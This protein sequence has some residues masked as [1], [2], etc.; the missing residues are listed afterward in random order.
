MTRAGPP[1]QALTRALGS[2]GSSQ[3]EVARTARDQSAAAAAADAAIASAARTARDAS[4]VSRQYAQANDNAARQLRTMTG[5][6]ERNAFAVRNLGQQFG[7]MAVMI[8]GGIDPGRAFATQ[9]GQIGYAMSDMSGKMGAVGRFL[10]GPWGIALTIAAGFLAPMV[11]KMLDASNAAEKQAEALASATAAADTYGSA[12]SQLGK[13]IELTTGKLKTQ[14]LELIQSIRLQAQADMRSAKEAQAKAGGALRSITDPTVGETFSDFAKTAASQNPAITFMDTAI[15]RGQ[16]LG[17]LKKTLEDYIALTNIAGV[18]QANLDRGFM[19]T[20]RSIDGLAR[21]GKLAGR[22]AIDAKA[23][24]VALGTTLNKQRAA[25]M[26]I[27]A[28]DGK[29][30]APELVPFQRTK[31]DKKPKSTA[32]RD[33]FG[34]DAADKIAGIVSQFDETPAV[35]DKTNAKVRE[36]D[37]LID[38]LGRRKPLGFGALIE[39]AEAAKTVVREG[40][41]R[42]VGKAFEQPKTLADRA[43]VAIGQLDAAIADL[44]ARKPAGFEQLIAD[45][46]TTQDVIRNGLQKPYAD[47]IRQ[48]QDGLAVQKLILAGRVGE[49]EALRTVQQLQQQMGPLTQAQKDAVLAT[50]EAMRAQARAI[51]DMHARAAKYTEAVSGISTIVQDATQQFVRGDLGQLIK[52]PGRL[53]DAFQT[54]NGRALF[55][56]LFSGVFQD[57]QDE[58]NGTSVV[59]DA[60][61]RMA[62]AV[63]A[64]TASTSRTTAAIDA[65][66][67]SA[68]AAARSVPGGAVG[69]FVGSAGSSAPA[70]ANDNGDIIVTGKRLR[71][72]SKD[73]TAFFTDALGRVG[74]SVAKAFTNPDTAARV[75]GAIGKFAGIGLQGAATGSIVAGVGKAIGIKLNS[76][77]S[78]IGGALGSFLPIP[79][80]SIIGSVVGGLIGNLFGKKAAY[81]TATLSGNDQSNVS[82]GGNKANAKSGANSLAGAVQEGLAQIVQQLGGTLGSYNVSI[83]TYDGKYRV[84]TSGQTGSLDFGKKNKQKATLHDFGDDQAGAIAFAIADAIADGAI[85]GLSARMQQ[86]IHSSTDINKALNEALKVQKLELDLGGVQAQLNK[87]F[88]DF[89]DQARERLRIATTY[90]FDVVAVEKKNAED[91][92]ALAQ[93]L[94]AQQVGSLQNLVDEM[95]RGSLFEGTAKDRLEA[96][97]K[98]IAKAKADFDAGK[99]GA[100]DTYAALLQQKL[101]ASKETYGTTS[102]YAA[103]RAATLNAAQAAIAQANARIV[104]GQNGGSDP[105]LATTN[106]GIAET[107]RTLDENNDQNAQIITALREQ[108]ELLA[109]AVKGNGGNSTFFD[110]AALSRV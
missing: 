78:Q 4:N 56:K 40:L 44:S 68:A 86:A 51:D 93:Q 57:L 84:S 90:G 47:F 88:R 60:S 91:R 70:A 77:G 35:L 14:N 75:G 11:S 102:A 45:A 33:E 41:I 71:G 61:D 38:D 99:E 22:D 103:D 55:D 81:G 83:G 23:A 2:L 64:V 69:G 3:E 73:P 15:R 16:Q 52:N 8:Q 34:R 19:A 20:L 85:Q 105:A 80:G 50:T 32:A 26:T 98:S 76:T 104:A 94:A 89:E 74:T 13:I 10:V 29:G 6:A 67:Q 63:D 9:A 48:Q 96:I 21:A 30:I 59:K 31:K 12:Q 42:E 7:D 49:A 107:N 36:L 110:L 108:N 18:S 106:A 92:A 109:K 95:T 97:N 5:D 27:D 58:I 43:K 39:Q 46:R 101:A 62:A 82:L 87:A 24:V 37:D 72:Y 53:L 25:Q 100:A 17:P 28:I 54:L 66:G 65:L 1:S 79:G